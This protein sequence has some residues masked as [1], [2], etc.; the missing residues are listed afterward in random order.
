MFYILVGVWVMC[1]YGFTKAYQ[2]VHLRSVHF[3]EC[4]TSI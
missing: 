4:K 2:V 1:I 3:T